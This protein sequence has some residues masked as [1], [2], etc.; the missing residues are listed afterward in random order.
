MILR[1]I[2]LVVRPASAKAEHTVVRTA[3]LTR[4]VLASA[5]Q[6]N[7]GVAFK[8]SFA[9][10]M[11]FLA[12]AAVMQTAWPIVLPPASSAGQSARLS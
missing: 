9:A 12:N 10:C 8:L 1:G 5:R 4:H 2:M 6:G 11:G 7:A 3:S